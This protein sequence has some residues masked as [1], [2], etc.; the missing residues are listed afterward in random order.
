MVGKKVSDKLIREIIGESIPPKGLEVILKHIVEIYQS[1]DTTLSSK[2]E[3][4]RL[5]QEPI[6]CYNLSPEL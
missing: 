2:E 1:M 4:M 5:F 6:E 3:Q